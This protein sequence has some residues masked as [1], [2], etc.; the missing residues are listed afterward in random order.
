[1]TEKEQL[2]QQLSEFETVLEN[3]LIKLCVGGGL[4]K[5]LM[6]SED[7]DLRWDDFIKDYVADAVTNITDYPEAAI[8]FSAFLG[9][10][11]AF[12]WDKDWAKFKDR[13]YSFYYGTHG[14]DDMDDHILQDVLKL[15]DS[16]VHKYSE[17]VKSLVQ[18]TLSL[19]RR[20]QIELQTE[21]GFYALVRCYGVLYRIGA[22]LEL[23]R[24]GYRL[25]PCSLN[26]LPS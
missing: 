16:E 24:E 12:H 2:Q 8:G 9:M 23:S 3:G 15:S 25:Q 10:A 6:S 7:I 1:M 13:K 20:E 5:E 4:M 22:S 17:T 26:T 11:V 19:L 21:F 14:F 18:A